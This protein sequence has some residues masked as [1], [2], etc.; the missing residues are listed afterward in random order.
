MLKMTSDHAHSQRGLLPCLTHPISLPSPHPLLS[1]RTAPLRSQPQ[2][3]A[4][5]LRYSRLTFIEC[6]LHTC[7]CE[8][9]VRINS[10]HLPNKPMR[11][12]L[13]LRCFYW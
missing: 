9:S 11:Q 1:S 3:L 12:A 7:S 5:H 10:F 4:D 8:R 13:L 2:L 6:L